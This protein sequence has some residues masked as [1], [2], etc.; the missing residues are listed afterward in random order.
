MRLGIKQKDHLNEYDE[1]PLSQKSAVTPN[2]KRGN[3]L[4]KLNPNF[5]NKFNDKDQGLNQ[6][7][8]AKNKGK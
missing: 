2:Q 4:D 7:R 6:L 5:L 3:F 8:D 1:V